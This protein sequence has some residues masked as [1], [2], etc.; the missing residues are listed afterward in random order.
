M[1]FSVDTTSKRVISYFER[2]AQNPTMETV[3]KLSKILDIVPEKLLN[4]RKN[5]TNEPKAIRSLQKRLSI[6]HKLPVEDQR[7]IAKTIELIAERN[8]VKFE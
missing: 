3:I 5:L 1:D 7:Y 8:G 2:E 4:P 6:V